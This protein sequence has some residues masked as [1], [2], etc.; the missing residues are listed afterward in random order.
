MENHLSTAF[1]SQSYN[2]T[3]ALSVLVTFSNTIA[4]FFQ[5]E[6]IGPMLQ[7]FSLVLIIRAFIS[8][9]MALCDR[10]MDFRK[11]TLISILAL[12]AGTLCKIVLVS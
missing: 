12:I 7:F 10:H 8:V 5:K 4:S 3:I 11:I 1:F 6:A 9:Q 2:G